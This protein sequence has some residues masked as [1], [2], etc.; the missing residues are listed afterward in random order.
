MDKIGNNTVFLGDALEILKRLPDESIDCVITSP[1]YYKLRTYSKDAIKI[2]NGKSDCIHKFNEDNFCE[3]CNAWRGELGQEP[4]VEMY[5]EHLLEITN[6]IKRVLKPTGNF[7][8][9]IFTTFKSKEDLMI[10]EKLVVNMVDKQGW[11]KRRTIIWHKPNAVPSSVKDDFTIDF[12]Y[13]YRFTKTRDAWFQMIF[14]PYTKPLNRWGGEEIV[15]KKQSIWDRGTG[16]N[17][18]RYRSLRPNPLGRN[19]R[20]VWSIP[21]TPS[22]IEHFATY[23]PALVKDLILSSCPPYVCSKCDKPYKATFNKTKLAFEYKPTC[24]CSAPTLPGIVLDP[25]AGS[26]TTL[27]VAK[28]LNRRYIGIEIVPKF[29]ETILR[30]LNEQL[31]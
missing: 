29:Y 4:T 13:V 21:T 3:V 17:L 12:E 6:E 11:I 24:T 19:K 2:W 25:F 20:C 9:N 8:L 27:I 26:G 1:P 31:L 28:Q 15:P 5:I 16:Q 14:E 30:R 10:P 18:Y 7:Y 23:P 22:F